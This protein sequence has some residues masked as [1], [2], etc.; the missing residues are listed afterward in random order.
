MEPIINQQMPMPET[1]NKTWLWIITMLLVAGLVGAG[2]YYWQNMEAKKMATATEE[3]TRNEMQVKI[4]EAESKINTLQSQ[5]TAQQKTIDDLAQQKNIFNIFDPNV[6][7]V[8]DKIVDMTVLAIGPVSPNTPIDVMQNYKATFKGQ[9]NIS[10]KFHL[11]EILGDYC[12]YIDQ[13]DWAKIPQSS[14]DNRAPQFCISNPDIQ[15]IKKIISENNGNANITIDDYTINQYPTEI[16]NQATL[17]KINNQ[18]S[19]NLCTIAPTP[20]EAGYSTYPIDEKYKNLRHLGELFTAAD[21]NNPERLSKIFGVKG[22]NYTIGANISLKNSP[23]TETLNT[24]KTIGFQCAEKVAE[25]S[26]KQW[27]LKNT[28]KLNDFLKLKNFYQE[29]IGSDCINCG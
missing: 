29:I 22:E 25:T 27:Q 5:L 23:S 20:N 8:G 15:A 28:V 7:K 4:T 24:L 2:I 3:K 21:C 14:I 19:N 16:S 1:K 10:G 18:S 12:M 17:I 11:D 13:P 26:C 9:A 6:L